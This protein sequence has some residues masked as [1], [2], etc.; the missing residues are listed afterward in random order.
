MIDPEKIK[1][2]IDDQEVDCDD[3]KYVPFTEEVSYLDFLSL[4]DKMTCHFDN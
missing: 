3:L 4:Y 1:C 2:Y